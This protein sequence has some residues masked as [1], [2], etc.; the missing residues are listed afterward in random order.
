MVRV[1]LDI[2]GSIFCMLTLLS[3]N[4]SPSHSRSFSLTHCCRHSKK[5]GKCAPFSR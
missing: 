1:G 3:W 4:R 2:P 5:S